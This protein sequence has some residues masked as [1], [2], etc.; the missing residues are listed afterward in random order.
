M[1]SKQQPTPQPEVQPR[2]NKAFQL[3]K[4]L[5]LAC[6]RL[7][8]GPLENYTHMATLIHKLNLLLLEIDKVS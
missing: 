7:E 1:V 8:E 4:Q 3:N 5:I 6:R 2:F